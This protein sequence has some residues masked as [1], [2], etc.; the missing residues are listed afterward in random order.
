MVGLKR[1]MK[2]LLSGQQGERC[3]VPGQQYGSDMVSSP[4]LALVSVFLLLGIMSY[5]HDQMGRQKCF[6][7]RNVCH[8]TGVK[9]WNQSDYLAIE[10][11]T[12]NDYTAKSH[13]APR[14]VV[15]KIVE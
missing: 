1:F 8:I 4:F 11:W 3:H 2:M 15:S 13:M 12:K 10:G 9:Y 7:C 6:M 14:I 5:G